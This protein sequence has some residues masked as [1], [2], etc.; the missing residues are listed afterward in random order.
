M[1][2]IILFRHGEK[3]KV[4]FNG[5]KKTITCLSN[6]GV[7]QIT[8]LGKILK[9]KFPEFQEFYPVTDFPLPKTFATTFLP[10]P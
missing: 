9:T 8:K 10:K 6:S 7:K 2:K 3:Q 4:E 1:T 5:N